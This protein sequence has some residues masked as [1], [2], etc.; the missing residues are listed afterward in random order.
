MV[1]SN[2]FISQLGYKAVAINVRG[3]ADSYSPHTI[4]SYKLKFF[5]EDNIDVINYFN[6]EMLLVGHIGV[7]LYV[8]PQ[9]HITKKK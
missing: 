5:M 9:Q 1:K 8:G 2:L 4:Q 7:L 3:Y 6:K